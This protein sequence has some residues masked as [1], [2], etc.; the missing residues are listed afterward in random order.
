MKKRVVV[1]DES[2]RMNYTE[3]EPNSQTASDPP[4][5]RE[6]D[7]RGLLQTRRPKALTV[8]KQSH[9]NH[10]RKVRSLPWNDVLYACCDLFDI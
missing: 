9:T 6:R 2:A 10:V 1:T 5:S 8:L 7:A 3:Y 4:V